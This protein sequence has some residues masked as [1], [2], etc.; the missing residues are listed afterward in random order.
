MAGKYRIVGLPK[1]KNGMHVTQKVS[2]NEANVEAEKEK[3]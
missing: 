1:A 3:Q 2:R